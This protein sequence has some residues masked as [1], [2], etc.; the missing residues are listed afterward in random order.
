MLLSKRSPFTVR[1]VAFWTVKDGLLQRE[2]PP[3]A[4]P[5]ADDCS[6]S[7]VFFTAAGIAVWRKLTNFALV[8]II[9]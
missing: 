7:R 4:K 3:F 8:L 1:K 2:R 9:R 5:T 6:V